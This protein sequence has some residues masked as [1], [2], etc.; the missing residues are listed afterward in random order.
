MPNKRKPTALKVLE[1][2]NQP[3][4]ANPAEP[5]F[6]PTEGAVRPDWL[7]GPEAVK[8]WDRLAGLLESQRVLTDADLQTLGHLC[9]LHAKCV[10]K[11]RLGAQ[12]TAAELTQL[13][14]MNV[15][16]GLTPA[17]R[18]KV[19]SVGEGK[20]KNKFAGLAG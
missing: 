16:F 6:E 12:P 15:E 5:E 19:S 14:M 1:G 10:E 2:T 9:N 18:A 3:V 11:W 8:E 7:N 17:S 13:R 20:S 4:R